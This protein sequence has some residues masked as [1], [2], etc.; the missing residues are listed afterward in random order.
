MEVLGGDHRS[1]GDGM[2][3]LA[4]WSSTASCKVLSCGG[5]GK[6]LV[7]DPASVTTEEVN[8]NK[9]AKLT[10]L[11]LHPAGD[12]VAVG[13]DA[14]FVKVFK[15]PSGEFDKVATRFSLPVRA[16]VFSPSGTSIAAAGDDDGIKLV[17]IADSKV[18]RTLKA[19]PY[20]RVLAYECDGKYLAS[21]SANGHLQI[22]DT[23]TGTAHNIQKAAPK[24]DSASPARSGLAWHPDGSLLAV[25]D[26]NN[27]ITI[28]EKLSW[29]PVI[30]LDGH[31]EPVNC[32]KFSPNGLYI[33][34]ASRNNEVFIWNLSQ[35]AIIARCKSA[36]LVSALAWHPR[37]DENVLGGIGEDGCIALWR[38]VIPHNLPQPADVEDPSPSVQV[39]E[40]GD[41]NGDVDSDLSASA[42]QHSEGAEDNGAMSGDT[43]GS[44]HQE[45]PN[46]RAQPN[47]KHRERRLQGGP[48]LPK[49][50]NAIQPGSTPTGEGKRRWLAYNVMGC[51]SS[52]E[53]D[54]F[55]VVEVSFH[56]TSRHRKRVPLL[57]DFYHFSMASLGAK[58]AF[59]ASTSCA[60]AP[61]M[62]MYRPFESW[63][64]NSDW[65]V[66][67]PV[68]E[69]ACAVAAG[70]SFCAIATSRQFLRIFSAAGL[71]LSITSIP[72]RIVALAAHDNMVALA[73]HSGMPA[74]DGS[75]SLAYS[76][77]RM[78]VQGL[79]QAGMLCLSPKTS[80]AWFGFSEEGMLASYDSTGVMRLCC[81]AYGGSWVPV[82]E[83]SQ[84]CAESQTC[85]PVGVSVSDI[86]CIISAAGMSGPQVVPRPVLS[87]L[88]MR[89]PVVAVDAAIAP[90]EADALR[91]NLHLAH[92]RES[93]GQRD[94]AGEE[95]EA[96]Q[97]DA[98]R[99][100]L[101]VFHAAL[102]AEK[103]ARA[104]EV[105]AQLALPVSLQGAL[106]LATHHRAIALAE[107]VQC[108]IEEA[109]KHYDNFPYAAPGSS[110]DYTASEPAAG[111]ERV[112]DVDAF[113]R[114][115]SSQMLRERTVNTNEP[116]QTHPV[117]TTLKPSPSKAVGEKRKEVAGNPFARKPK[118]AK[119]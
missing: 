105:A 23:T 77:Y 18:F 75:Q 1:H 97:K 53:D 41:T 118:V 34:S 51:I 62:V 49:M 36:T 20:T 71:Q 101:R 30:H 92:M 31:T 114:P 43:A 22:W 89:F 65:T 56:D 15:L 119:Q 47:S 86:Y 108:L 54:G 3:D 63:A 39:H 37:K 94:D 52:R 107:R 85:W 113:K 117:G 103:V 69:E 10:C 17:N 102:K 55:C 72:G 46:I 48:K 29:D 67:L 60:D 74:Q 93:E 2:S 115:I 26:T 80:L 110:D 11:A 98:D 27:G 106:R 76:V 104:L 58:G 66:G 44:G 88:P 40:I 81:S 91:L 14:N 35:R 95:L 42:A 33:A 87:V 8:V 64:P 70:E 59:F 24:V 19:G 50:Q 45:G 82:F 25:S 90:L 116:G 4:W 16:I 83:S 5:D 57:N 99:T 68:G 12:V 32:L 38:N 73:W 96:A 28:Y 6:L 109:T 84:A 78:D 79:V 9:T 21:V 100:L 7:T 13:D 111:S 112:H 61:S